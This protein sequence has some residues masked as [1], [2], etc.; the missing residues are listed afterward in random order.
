MEY[1]NQNM[2]YMKLY[3]T[4]RLKFTFSVLALLHISI[5]LVL[6]GGPGWPGWPG[7]P[8]IY[9]LEASTFS[10]VICLLRSAALFGSKAT[11]QEK[12]NLCKAIVA[13]PGKSH[14][15]S[16]FH[17]KRPGKYKVF[18]HILDWYNQKNVLILWVC[19]LSSHCGNTAS[20][21]NRGQGKLKRY[22]NKFW[23]TWVSLL[24]LRKHIFPYL[25]FPLFI[26]CLSQGNICSDIK[27]LHKPLTFHSFN[28]NSNSF[29]NLALESNHNI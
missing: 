22:S 24:L 18:I 12:K 26:Y 21:S 20:Q 7:G 9:A 3:H 2:K 1:I 4:R 10:P 28:E 25:K 6:P 5:P 23:K 29:V 14:S 13:E 27:L 15:Y 11:C 8:G 19:S 17:V 16:S